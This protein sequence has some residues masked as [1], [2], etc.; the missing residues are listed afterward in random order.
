M[1]KNGTFSFKIL[2][3]GAVAPSDQCVT[4]INIARNITVAPLKQNLHFY[5]HFEKW[6]ICFISSYVLKSM[7]ALCISL[8][9]LLFARKHEA[10]D[11]LSGQHEASK[12]ID[13][14]I[15]HILFVSLVQKVKERVRSIA[16]YHISS[17][18]SKIWN[19]YH[20]VLF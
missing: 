7:F 17:L 18:T 6:S 15:L 10:Y 13:I 20:S 9:F 3:N 14:R 5:T 2:K 4:F 19:I 16:S 8:C 1:R 11:N 12:D